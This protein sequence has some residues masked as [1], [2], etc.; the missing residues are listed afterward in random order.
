LQNTIFDSMLL[1]NKS[2]AWF[3]NTTDPQ[4]V[5]TTGQYITCVCCLPLLL[6]LL[7]LLPLTL[8]RIS[9]KVPFCTPTS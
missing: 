5:N 6:P 4:H 3:V 2:F 9:P 1:A 7:S 8:P